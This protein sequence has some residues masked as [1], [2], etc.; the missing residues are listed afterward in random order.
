M[1]IIERGAKPF[2]NLVEEVDG[3]DDYRRTSEEWLRR[4]RRIFI[5]PIKFSRMILHLAPFLIKCPVHTLTSISFMLFESWNKM[6][7]G[8]NTPTKLLRHVWE[9]K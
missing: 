5:N 6:F 3:T 4:G 8:Q 1:F 7:R 9:Y 2:F